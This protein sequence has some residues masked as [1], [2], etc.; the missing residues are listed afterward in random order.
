MS[1]ETPPP[2]RAGPRWRRRTRF[3]GRVVVGA[4]LVLCLLLAFD[5]SPAD[6]ARLRTFTTSVERWQHDPEFRTVAR[7]YCIAG[8]SAMQCRPLFVPA[9]R[10]ILALRSAPGLPKEFAVNPTSRLHYER[11]SR[12]PLSA[13]LHLCGE[14]EVEGWIEAIEPL[15]A[16]SGRTEADVRAWLDQRKMDFPIVKDRGAVQSVIQLLDDTDA[17]QPF[18]IRDHV[19]ERLAPDIAAV[20]SELDLPPD[21]LAM[22]PDQQQAVLDR[23]D[24]YVHRHD[25]QLWRTKQIND[26]A[27]GI[28]AQVFG[29]PYNMLLVPALAIQ[30]TARLV[31]I[32]LLALLLVATRWRRRPQNASG[33]KASRLAAADPP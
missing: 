22:T 31:L 16:K 30:T 12:G 32:L 5:L 6:E 19:V 26:F 27:G 4:V 33:S 21:P 25:V 8:S 2:Q 14:Q 18:P 23:L 17:A 10:V 9:R 3:A 29:P 13:Y 15:G 7:E 20:A 28:W 24:D 1:D 11:F